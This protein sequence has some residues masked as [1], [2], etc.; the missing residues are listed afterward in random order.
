MRGDL[1]L[2]CQTSLAIVAYG[3]EVEHETYYATMAQLIPVVVLAALLEMR[4]MSRRLNSVAAVRMTWFDRGMLW[5]LRA[6]SVMI[7]CL[8]AYVAA[9]VSAIRFETDYPDVFD[10][11]F[12]YMFFATVSLLCGVALRI[13]VA[14]LPAPPSDG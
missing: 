13:V 4:A 8:L 6:L 14:P 12:I 2:F 5:S 7:F 11:S 1:S 10:L 3:Q 9:C